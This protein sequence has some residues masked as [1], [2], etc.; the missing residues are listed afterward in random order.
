LTKYILYRL[1]LPLIL[2]FGLCIYFNIIWPESGLFLNIASEVIGIL[3]TILY[4]NWILKQHEVQRWNST[5]IRIANRL[6]ILLNATI[7]SIRNGLG[8]SYDILDECTLK[9]NDLIV[10]HNELIRVAEH[11]ISP[12]TYQQV[13]ILDTKGWKSLATQ[14][15]NA[16]NGILM[17]LNAFQ[18]R[19]DPQQIANLL[20]LQEAL[21][22]SLT[23][24]VVF[25]DIAG[26]PEIELPKTRT[27]A[28]VLQ[29]S[30]Y[31]ETA[32][33]IQKALVLI[34]EISKSIIESSTNG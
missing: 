29:Q 18:V 2:L 27:P 34:K 32:K 20:D 15:T 33:E 7:S 22:N 4:I 5:D 30:G 17:F 26:I 25:P 6:R 19:L 13:C 28:I 23:F 11:V 1:V 8:L 31:E 9:S 14:I 3:I 10:V 21:S 16:H 24:Y 12:V